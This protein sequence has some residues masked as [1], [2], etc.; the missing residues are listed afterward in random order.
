MNDSVLE[1]T[2]FIRQTSSQNIRIGISVLE[3][4]LVKFILRDRLVGKGIELYSEEFLNFFVIKNDLMQY[5]CT[6]QEGFKHSYFVNYKL[7]YSQINEEKIIHIR[8]EENKNICFTL[9]LETLINIINMEP[10]FKAK[11]CYLENLDLKS[12]YTECLHRYVDESGKTNFCNFFLKK[13]CKKYD[14]LSIAMLEIIF[15]F[16]KY[17]L[18]DIQMIKLYR[19]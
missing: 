17:I 12:Y 4:F 2:Y 3:N 8:N 6:E 18:K 10:L 19:N 9:N 1:S 15:Y 13:Y 14:D 11:I 16:D 7:E 5:F